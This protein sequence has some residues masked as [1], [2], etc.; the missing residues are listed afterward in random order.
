MPLSPLISHLVPLW[1]LAPRLYLWHPLSIFLCLG[2][3]ESLL[4]WDPVSQGLLALMCLC[5]HVHWDVR[6]GCVA[7]WFRTGLPGEAL[8]MAR[9]GDQA[10]W[11]DR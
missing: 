2:L 9:W 4:S 10:G 5:L 3:Y 1:V 11:T 8:N 7:A 6:A